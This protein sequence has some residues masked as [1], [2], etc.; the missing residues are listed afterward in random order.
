MKNSNNF[1]TD[2]YSFFVLKK[3]INKVR[4]ENIFSKLKIDST[5]KTTSYNRTNDLNI[6]LKKHITK[7]FTK[8]IT[9]CD[10]GISSGQS[11]KELYDHLDKNKINYIYGF[12]KQINIKIY[13]LNNFVFLYS[14]KNELMMVEYDKYCL[15]FRYFYFFKKIEKILIHLFKYMNIKFK[16]TNV[17]IPDLEKITKCKFFEQDIFDIEKKYSN[18][19]D[20]VRVSNLLNYSYFSKSKLKKAIVNINKISKENCIVL[21]NRTTNKKKNTASFFRKRRG[22]FELLEDING[23]SEI[24]D[25]II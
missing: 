15:R 12:D 23:G 3:K 20:V 2:I 7:Y 1:Y 9:L 13:K 8:K 24:K 4:M 25:L 10:I 19:F 21:I 14:L 16:K 22:K 5:F 6:K 17:L 18:S 11:T